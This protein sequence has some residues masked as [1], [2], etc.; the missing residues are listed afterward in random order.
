METHTSNIA[1]LP[2]D[3]IPQ[4]TELPEQAM[5]SSSSYTLDKEIKELPQQQR[6]S[7]H[8][9]VDVTPNERQNNHIY[10]SVIIATLM[11]ILFNEPFI[12]NYIMN[13]LVVIFGSNLKNTLTGTTSK[14]G[15]I[16]YGIFYG[17]FIFI[18]ITN[19]PDLVI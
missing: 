2:I 12:R 6:V 4:N 3:H 7:F 15:N 17:I 11:F 8:P 9:N 5:N 14:M 13:I 1:D 18:I 16:F 10:K 19:S